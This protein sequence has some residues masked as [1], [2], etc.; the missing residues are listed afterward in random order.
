MPASSL[1]ASHAEE[2]GNI[3]VAEFRKIFLLKHDYC[4]NTACGW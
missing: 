2:Y 3:T 4:R 1:R